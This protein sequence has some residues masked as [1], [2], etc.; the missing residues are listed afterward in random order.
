MIKHNNKEEILRFN[1]MNSEE[2]RYYKH[3][4]PKEFYILENRRFTDEEDIFLLIRKGIF[5]RIKIIGYAILNDCSKL[6]EK[7]R[8]TVALINSIDSGTILDHEWVIISDFMILRL[9]RRRGIGSEFFR[10]IE[11][12]YYNNRQFILNA[13]GD[14]K[15]FW[16]KLGFKFVDKLRRTMVKK[17]STSE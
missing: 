12:D 15:F 11:N 14:G 10:H 5:N 13:D 1:K 17:S 2:Y 6:N 4:L 16:N 7:D 8:K 3:K 9:Q